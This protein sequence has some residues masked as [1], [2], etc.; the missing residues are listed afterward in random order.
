MDL[1]RDIQQ[2]C[3]AFTHKKPARLAAY[4]YGNRY[5]LLRRDSERR[6]CEL[7]ATYQR[8]GSRAMRCGATTRNSGGLR[9]G[10][11]FRL[12]YRKVPVS[13][14]NRLDIFGRDDHACAALR[15]MPESN[16]KVICQADA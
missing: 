6:E 9:Y 10:R 3:E 2:W 7:V 11:D 8:R 13:Y 5:D 14:L 4:E 15:E 12:R 1:N 16:G